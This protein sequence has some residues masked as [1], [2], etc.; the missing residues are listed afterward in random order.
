MML[1]LSHSQRN[2]GFGL[3]VIEDRHKGEE[4]PNHPLFFVLSE[5]GTSVFSVQH[6]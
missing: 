2:T 1:L 5:M 4:M 3:K 6:F